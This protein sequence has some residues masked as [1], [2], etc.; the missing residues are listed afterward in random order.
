MQQSDQVEVEYRIE[1][2]TS[3]LERCSQTLQQ[4]SI[5]CEEWRLKSLGLE[6]KIKEHQAHIGSQKQ[7]FEDLAENLKSKAIEV[8]DLRSKYNRV[9]FIT[10]KGYEERMEQLVGEIE[11]LNQLLM[12]KAQ[13][14]ESSRQQVMTKIQ[15]LQEERQKCFHLD[16]F[17][18]QIKSE[19]LEAL[20]F[21]NEK[22]KELEELKERFREADQYR[23]KSEIL[24]N[25][26]ETIRV[27]YMNI[28]NQKLEEIEALQAQIDTQRLI[29]EN[30]IRI[31]E[32]KY[33]Q[34]IQIER[35][36][37]QRQIKETVA[38]SIVQMENQVATLNNLLEAKQ[39]EIDKL[40]LQRHNIETEKMNSMLIDKNI[41]LQQLERQLY[42]RTNTLDQLTQQIQNGQ[43]IPATSQSLLERSYK[44]LQDDVHKQ[45][46]EMTM[47]HQR[48]LELQEDVQKKANMKA[49]YEGQIN[50]LLI[51]IANLKRDVYNKSRINSQHSENQR[52]IQIENEKRA[53]KQKYEQDLKIAEDKIR[54][55]LSIVDPRVLE[56][57]LQYRGNSNPNPL[58]QNCLEQHLLP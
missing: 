18:K 14:C 37:L 38:T 2:L 15:E 6:Q 57:Q 1:M 47:L 25:D 10:I 58:K 23:Q 34:Q 39:N 54:Y 49:N 13:D 33:A 53:I 51:E 21:L 5:E 22:N 43:L 19:K 20:H 52:L 16:S 42:E 41:K 26:I 9:Q 24:E 56:Q 28:F 35:V 55:L 17:I 45:N 29:N 4:K 30:T 44:Q 11:K 12:Q 31:S 27:N 3:E 36:N 50:T 40:K 48:C 7:Q 32:E 46:I 8:E